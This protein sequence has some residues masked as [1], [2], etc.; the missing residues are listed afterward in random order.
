MQTIIIIFVS[1]LV[2][3]LFALTNTYRK[4]RK[5]DTIKDL[6]SKL[7]WPILIPVFNTIVLVIY[8]VVSVG[9]WFLNIRIK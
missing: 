6:F 2:P 7:Q 3:I 4:M 1:W 9:R 8:I 5:G